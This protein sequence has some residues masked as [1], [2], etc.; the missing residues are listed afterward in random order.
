M[1]VPVT[2][3]QRGVYVTALI[4]SD[5]FNLD[6]PVPFIVDSGAQDTTLSAS[7]IYFH[8]DEIDFSNLETKEAVGICGI[9]KI[10]LLH[11]TTLYFCSEQGEWFIGGVF[12]EIGLIPPKYKPITNQLIPI[13]SLLGLDLIGIK[14]TF[15]YEAGNIYLEF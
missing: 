7:Y 12:E 1:R 3:S 11:N 13:P 5:E 8:N 14:F 9:C 2:I 10:F 6:T 15:H 4:R